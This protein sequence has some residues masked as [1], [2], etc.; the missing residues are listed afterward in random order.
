MIETTFKEG[1]KFERIAHFD[2]TKPRGYKSIIKLL[3]K[4][5]RILDVRGNGHNISEIKSLEE[6]DND[7]EEIET[8]EEYL[9]TSP[10][11]EDN[12]TQSSSIVKTQPP[13]PVKKMENN[14]QNLRNVLFAQLEKLSEENCDVE[15]EVKRTN[16]M[17]QLSQSIISSASIELDLLKLKSI[18]NGNDIN[19]SFIQSKQISE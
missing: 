8:S 12:L 3:H 10:E 7:L 2:K 17:V 15:K 9:H 16:S 13:K 11:L 18:S 6:E 4:N 1:D 5:G 19:S 14:I